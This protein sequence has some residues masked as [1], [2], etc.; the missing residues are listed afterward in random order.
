MSLLSLSLSL[1][2][3]LS[4]CVRARAY[5]RERETQR[6]TDRL[7]QGLFLF[8]AVRGMGSVWSEAMKQH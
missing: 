4:F 5:E 8:I 6:Q 3:P 1:P 2:P 7:L